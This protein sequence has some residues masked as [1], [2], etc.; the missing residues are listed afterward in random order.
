LGSIAE[1]VV[2]KRGDKLTNAVKQ[3]YK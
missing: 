3:E 1:F 2:G